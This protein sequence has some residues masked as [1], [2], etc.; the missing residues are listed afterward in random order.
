MEKNQAI[1]YSLYYVVIYFLVN[2]SKIFH[3]YASLALI[4][5]GLLSV[6]SES[7]RGVQYVM[8][9]H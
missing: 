8:K 6:T 5:E 7:T 9:T 1:E 4:Q 3:K 2:I